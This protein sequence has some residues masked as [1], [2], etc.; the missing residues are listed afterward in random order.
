MVSSF[1]LLLLAGRPTQQRITPA[2]ASLVS[3]GR[4]LEEGGLRQ[5]A[6]LTMNPEIDI[7][8]AAKSEVTPLT[9][10][11]RSRIRYWDFFIID[12]IMR[13]SRQVAMKRRAAL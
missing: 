6:L 4:A 5:G 1:W 11:Q 8:L 2:R 12:L 13:I 9:K 3:R 10:E 7:A